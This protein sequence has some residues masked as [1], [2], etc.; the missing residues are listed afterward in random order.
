MK[1]TF[2]LCAILI[3]SMTSCFEYVDGGEEF[4]PREPINYNDYQAINYSRSEIDQ[5]V[6]LMPPQEMINSGK[7]YVFNDMLFVGE[8]RKGF[9]VF[10][11]SDQRNPQKIKFI[12]VLGST[13]L[14]IRNDV[15]YV[16][17]AADLIALRY[18]ASQDSLQLMKRVPNSFPEYRSPYGYSG[19]HSQDSITV[20]WVKTN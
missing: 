20:G 16:N 3:L 9:H 5:T 13:D 4:I 19:T 17:Q 1:N 2:I 8:E 6:K 14:S 7:I 15:L 12:Q 11:N 10:D 18:D